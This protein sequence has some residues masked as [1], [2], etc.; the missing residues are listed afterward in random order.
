MLPGGKGVWFASNLRLAH[1]DANDTLITLPICHVN[2]T[3]RSVLLKRWK[4]PGVS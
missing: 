1:S 3:Q 2:K 4:S